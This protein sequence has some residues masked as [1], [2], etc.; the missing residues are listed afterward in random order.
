MGASN[1]FGLRYR[2][3]EDRD[4]RRLAAVGFNAPVDI[5]PNF[6]RNAASKLA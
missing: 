2:F 1:P 5:V 4:R 3:S 6:T